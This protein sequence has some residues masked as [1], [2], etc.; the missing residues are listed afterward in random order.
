MRVR[1]ISERGVDE[2]ESESSKAR[3]TKGRSDVSWVR[4]TIERDQRGAQL[5]PGSQGSRSGS[6]RAA[7]VT[8]SSL[9]LQ[10]INF[11][12]IC[13]SKSTGCSNFHSSASLRHQFYPPS[14][15]FHLFSFISA[16]YSCHIS[17]APDLPLALPLYFSRYM[18]F[19]P[20]YTPTFCLAPH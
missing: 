18:S 11:T 7:K 3:T 9:Q 13:P 5:G 12:Q 17:S 20:S 1:T 19:P 8:V 16:S 15:L 14:A 4:G 6:G 2:R 10:R